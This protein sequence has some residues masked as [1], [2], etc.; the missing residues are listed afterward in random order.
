MFFIYSLQLHNSQVTLYDF[1]RTKDTTLDLLTTV[2]TN[3][4]LKESGEKRAQSAF[5]DNVKES[6]IMEDGYY[7]RHSEK[8]HEIN[9][10]QRKTV[11]CPGRMWNSY[12]VKFDHVMVFGVT[13]AALNMPIDFTGKGVTSPTFQS[14][15]DCTNHT[16]HLSELKDRL[17]LQKQKVDAQIENTI[18]LNDYTED[19]DESSEE[20]LDLTG[21]TARLQ[22]QIDENY[23]KN[24]YN[25]TPLDNRYLSELDKILQELELSEE[26][27]ERG[28][29]F[30]KN[31]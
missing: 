27:M 1:C 29:K 19:E 30:L 10:Y 25:Q 31:D 23:M 11:I 3:F 17:K 20:E 9:V 4:I 16:N 21:P 2:A 8:S 12:E 26:D 15:L 14:S 7:L 13:E 18:Q 28:A 5:I 6:D 22:K 24:L